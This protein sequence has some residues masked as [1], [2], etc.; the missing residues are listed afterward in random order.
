MSKSG[1]EEV[2]RDSL[3]VIKFLLVAGFD[4]FWRGEVAGL[5]RIGAELGPNWGRLGREVTDGRD[6]V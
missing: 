1:M 6:S 2:F 5:K 3:G 4:E